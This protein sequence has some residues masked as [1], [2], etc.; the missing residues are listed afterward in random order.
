MKRNHLLIVLV[1][2][3]VAAIFATGGWLAHSALV[4][5]RRDAR[6][7][8][9]LENYG[10][11]AP[12]DKSDTIYDAATLSGGGQFARFVIRPSIQRL[13]DGQT[14]V[15]VYRYLPTE[16]RGIF[17]EERTVL[18]GAGGATCA[19]SPATNLEDYRPV[20]PGSLEAAIWQVVASG[21]VDGKS[22][23]GEVVSH[24]NSR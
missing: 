14:V 2:V 6:A 9:E 15:S 10:I 13:A 5:F 16:P 23:S 18:Y 12:W 3:V 7:G 24:P 1:L 21:A 11:P 17:D 22:P 8:L 20:R 19:V 4:T